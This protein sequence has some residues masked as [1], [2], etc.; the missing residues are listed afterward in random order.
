MHWGGGDSHSFR[1]AILNVMVIKIIAFSKAFRYII[2]SFLNFY[3]LFFE[4][5]KCSQRTKANKGVVVQQG[6]VSF[7]KH[8]CNSYSYLGN[9]WCFMLNTISTASLYLCPNHLHLCETQS[10]LNEHTWNCLDGIKS[11]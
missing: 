1:S 2:L 8:G 3:Q 10:A 9:R 5:C 4:T 7:M 11:Q 6:L